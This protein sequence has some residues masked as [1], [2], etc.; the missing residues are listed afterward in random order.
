[1][2]TDQTPRSVASEIA[3]HCLQTLEQVSDPKRV[4]QRKFRQLVRLATF[5]T[6][7]LLLYSFEYINT[8]ILQLL[9]LPG[10]C[11]TRVMQYKSSGYNW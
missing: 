11:F 7:Q 5:P 1:M 2:D 4:K 8:F 10:T 3:L 9:L 6:L